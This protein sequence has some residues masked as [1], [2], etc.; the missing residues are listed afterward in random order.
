M[1]YTVRT[2]RDKAEKLIDED[3]DDT[4]AYN[5]ATD[6]LREE[7]DNQLWPRTTQTFATAVADTWYTLADTFV[8]VTEDGVTN[9]AG[10]R[11]YD[12]TISGRQ[13]KFVDADTYTL[14]YRSTPTALTS[15]DG[16]TTGT[17]ALPDLF[18]L[19]MAE[20]ECFKFK[21][22]DSP[23]DPDGDK[24]LKRCRASL[25]KVYNALQLNTGES[26]R[27]TPD[28]QRRKGW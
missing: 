10:V 21:T 15:L 23:D 13:I 8:H 22:A 4:D 11:Y 5:W 9:A 6:F 2:V 18:I 7:L 24:W 17:I 1:S 26:S 12:Y 16:A 25:G 3:I 28:S 20:Y 14:N 27:K 19:P